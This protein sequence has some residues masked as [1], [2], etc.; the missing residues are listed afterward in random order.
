MRFADARTKHQPP[1][2]H[3]RRDSRIRTERPKRTEKLYRLVVD[4]TS[5]LSPIPFG[6]T[7]LLDPRYCTRRISI[8]KGSFVFFDPSRL[9]ILS[10]FVS[11][12]SECDLQAVCISTTNRCCLGQTQHLTWSTSTDR[13]T[14]ILLYHG[15]SNVSEFRPFQRHQ[16]GS[17]RRSSSTSGR[18]ATER[19]ARCLRRYKP[20]EFNVRGSGIEE[21]S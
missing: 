16:H 1:P 5:T 10:I 19:A 2:V 18:R 8:A 11:M 4:D 20:R 7:L 21:G 13:V 3:V 17:R 6:S 9:S 15:R 14:L 12:S